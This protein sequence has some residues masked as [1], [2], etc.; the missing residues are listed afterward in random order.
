MLLSSSLCGSGKMGLLQSDIIEL[1]GDGLKIKM[2]GG[3]RTHR[4]LFR[5][6]RD[7]GISIVEGYDSHF[8]PHGKSLMCELF[9]TKTGHSWQDDFSIQLFLF[10]K[11]CF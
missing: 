9:I 1:S 6:V 4:C 5:R 11:E 3:S 8:D 10:Y 7:V 2:G